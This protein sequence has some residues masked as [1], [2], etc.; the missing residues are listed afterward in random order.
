MKV[1][2]FGG[3]SVKDAA[4]VRN[5][6]AIVKRFAGQELIIVV[7][8]MAKTTNNLERLTDAFFYKKEDPQAVLNEIKDFHLGILKELFPD[9]TTEIYAQV[10]SDFVEL[11]W[12]IEDEPTYEYNHEY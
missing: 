2:K 5:V 11:Q 6:A 9:P 3:A 1:F 4:A 10:E 12:A 7:S 8:A